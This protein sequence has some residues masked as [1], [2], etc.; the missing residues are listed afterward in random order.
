MSGDF[1]VCVVNYEHYPERQKHVECTSS[2]C[3]TEVKQCC[4]ILVSK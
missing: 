3:I 4:A 2:G 1:Q